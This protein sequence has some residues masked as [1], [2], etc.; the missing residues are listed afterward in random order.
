MPLDFSTHAHEY[1]RN[2]AAHLWNSAATGGVAVLWLDPGYGKTMIVLHAFKALYDAGIV[3]N[4]MIVAPLRVAQTVWGQEI[5]EWA[6]LNGLVACRLHGTKKENQLRR[7][8]VNI[9]IV[10]YEGIPWAIKMAK[11]GKMPQCDVVVYD[12]IRRMKNAQGKRF[13]AARPLTALAKFKW[14]LTG[15]PASNGLLDLFG[16]FL[17]L[18]DG[19]SLGKYIT[20]YRSAYFEQGYDGFSWL[21]R[22]GAQQ[23]IEDRIKPYIYRADGY[24]D[25]PEFVDDIRK[26]VLPAGAMKK[27]REM[28]QNLITEMEADQI[29]AANAAVLV[30]KLKQMANGRVY[31]ED[32]KII[33]LHAEKQEALKDLIDELGDEQLL[34]AY[35]FNHDLTQL[36]EVLGDELPYLGAG[37][38]EKTAMDNVDKWNSG[39]IRVMAAHPASAGHG[40]NL[41]KGNAH[42]ILWWGPT[43]DL[44]HYIQFNRRLLRQGNKSSHVVVHTFVT[45]KTVDETVIIA[46]TEKDGIQSGLLSAL[47]AEFGDVM[48]T[49]EETKPKEDTSMSELTFKSDANQQPQQQA[50]STNPFAQGQSG[51]QAPAPS[52]NPFAPQQQAPA[53]VQQQAAPPQ[54][55]SHDQ[56]PFAQGGQQQAPAPAQNPFAPQGG[57]Q[58]QQ[59]I[60]Q[61]VAAAPIPQPDPS[62]APPNPFAQTQAP[63]PVQQQAP[64]PQQQQAPVVEDAQV[65][66]QP[67]PVA[68]PPMNDTGWTEGAAEVAQ[69]TQAPMAS[70][71]VVVP[72]SMMIPIDKMD[73]VMSAIGRA[74]K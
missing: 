67:A 70:S 38:N 43:I 5:D 29:T 52:P 44:D 73:K 22:P 65:V 48:I 3:K 72:I 35:E 49:P 63:A 39:E 60:E 40:L 71:V 27:Y 50:A 68:D 9:W 1:Q 14:G 21:P 2:G 12:E 30:G 54:E 51:G 11:E 6:S 56:N 42:H 16:Q 41:Q 53:P 8:D 13:K 59:H 69:E 47:T 4:M 62:T 15:T 55:Q 26:I 74:L 34:I 57:G 7:R 18:D 66:E 17:I 32:R 23:M 28:K 33:K 24:L 64:A 25:L 36:R 20:K 46:R 10:N 58:Q 31:D 61:A 37:I 19:V 45:E